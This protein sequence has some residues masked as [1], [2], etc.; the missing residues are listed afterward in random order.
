MTKKARWRL[1][2]RIIA[3][4]LAAVWSGGGVGLAHGRWLV[5]LLGPP[6]IWYG[7]VWVRV[8][9]EGRRLTWR[10]ARVAWRRP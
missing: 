8:A 1:G 6:A 4:I 5:A 9:F 2:L 10:E 7:L 3:A